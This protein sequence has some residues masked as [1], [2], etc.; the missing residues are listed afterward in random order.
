MK[1]ENKNYP[2]WNIFVVKKNQP[3]TKYIRIASKNQTKEN[4]PLNAT[5]PWRKISVLLAHL[6]H[7]LFSKWHISNISTP[8]EGETNHTRKKNTLA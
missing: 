3:W 2:F 6:N 5:Y 8:S 7:V 1:K 4:I